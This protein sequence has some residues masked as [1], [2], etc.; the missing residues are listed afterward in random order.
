MLSM[1]MQDLM[2]FK[3]LVETVSQDDGE[4]SPIKF[5]QEAKDYCPIIEATQSVFV[6]L[7]NLLCALT[8]SL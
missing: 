6:N 7:M 2:S 1:A 5:Y 8:P 3:G 4:G